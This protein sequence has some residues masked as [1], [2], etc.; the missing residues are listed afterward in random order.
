MS[1]AE[2]KGDVRK[3][4]AEVGERPKAEVGFVDRYPYRGRRAA[5]SASAAIPRC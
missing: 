4:I 2:V 5:I 1:A 3:P